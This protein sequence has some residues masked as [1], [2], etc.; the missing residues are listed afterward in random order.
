MYVRTLKHRRTV[1]TA[2][3]DDLAPGSIGDPRG[4]TMAGSSTDVTIAAGS[5]EDYAGQVKELQGRNKTI[6]SEIDALKQEAAANREKITSLIKL[7]N[8]CF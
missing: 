6:S 1:A 2:V 8:P 3:N 4:L 5:Y 7:K